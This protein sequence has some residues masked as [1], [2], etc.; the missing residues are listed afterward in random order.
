MKPCATPRPTQAALGQDCGAAQTRMGR[1]RAEAPTP[2]AIFAAMDRG[3]FDASTGVE[4]EDCMATEKV[5]MIKIK[6]DK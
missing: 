6:E 1:V 3:D 2:Q 5:M 4:L